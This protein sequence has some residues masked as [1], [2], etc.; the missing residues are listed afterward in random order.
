MVDEIKELLEDE[1][2]SEITN[3]SLMESGSTEHTAAVENLSKLYKLK[4][5]EA[6]NEREFTESAKTR[7][8][9]TQLKREQMSEQVKDRYIKLCMDVA[10]LVLPLMFYA[11]WMKK[12]FKFEESG[13]FTST[14]FRGLFSRF[15][16]SKN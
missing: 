11:S 16:P 7:E 15:R 8:I 3:L 4:I 14:T 13:T 5:E 10:G 9:E 1:I 6:K 12:G 2:K